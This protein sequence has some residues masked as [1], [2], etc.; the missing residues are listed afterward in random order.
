MCECK[1]L[2][3]DMKVQK[4][5]KK[6]KIYARSRKKITGRIAEKVVGA[7]VTVVGVKAIDALLPDSATTNRELYV[8]AIEVGAGVLIDEFYGGNN[9]YVDE[10]AETMASHGLVELGNA[11]I[12]SFIDSALLSVTTGLSSLL[13]G[14]SSS[15]AAL[16]AA[17]LAAATT[18]NAPTDCLGY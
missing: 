17:A 10:I 5:K 2:E 11:T 3:Q 6:R 4:M 7:G 8:S 1:K 18:S 14:T 15:Q 9:D 16:N 12:G 13:G